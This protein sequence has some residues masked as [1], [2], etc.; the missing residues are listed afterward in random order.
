MHERKQL[1]FV[2][3]LTLSFFITICML[4]IL[5]ALEYQLSF[6]GQHN[7][8]EAM[9]ESRY[10]TNA[11]SK[12]KTKLKELLKGMS[13]P[14][15]LAEQMIV[16]DQ[17]Y[18]DMTNYVD[19]VYDG[20][21]A[22]I[23]TTRFKETFTKVMDEYLLDHN[24]SVSVQLD[25]SMKEAANRAEH[26]YTQYLKPSFAKTIYEF[27]ERYSHGISMMG[28]ISFIMLVIIVAILLLMYQYKHHA[29]RYIIY[30]MVAATG[31][32]L[33]AIILLKTIDLNTSLGVGPEYYMSF[34]QQY[35]Q[36]GVYDGIIISAVAIAGI[37]VLVGMTR[38]LK[39]TIK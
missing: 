3:S 9:S 1:R 26:T 28:I 25:K 10:I 17:I 6:V 27:N 4:N 30:G 29:V 18:L 15:D 24:I 5:F 31:I 14:E 16:E 39:H 33:I 34:L 2:L 13:L 11:Q 38:R 21:T 35:L 12:V 32:N 22:T 23:D 19:A 36:A 20:K 7:V 37:L 8:N